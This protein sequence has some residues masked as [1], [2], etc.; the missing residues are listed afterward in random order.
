MPEL[1]AL[2]RHPERAAPDE[3]SSILAAGLVAHVG[4]VCDG[5][6]QVIP[7][8]YHYD[9]AEPGF[10]YMH[11]SRESRWVRAMLEGQTVCVEVALLDGIVYSKRTCSHSVNF[12]S[13]VCYGR[14]SA[15]EDR[16]RQRAV[17]EGIVTRYTPGRK[18]GVDFM[19]PADP[20]LDAGALIA[21][22]I[23]RWSAKVRRGGPKG[24]HD[25]DPSAPG[26]SGVIETTQR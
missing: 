6:P 1:V 3:C 14:G 16:A 8:S 19:P 4:F 26:T 13:V 20:E 12:R 18:A 23:E 2:R 25:S 22:Q 5:V 15:V 24:P 9:P 10:L 11:G 17:Y 21:F 7:V